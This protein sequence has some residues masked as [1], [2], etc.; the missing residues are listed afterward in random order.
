[1]YMAVLY[2]DIV[3]VSM[4]F[5]VMNMTQNKFNGTIKNITFNIHLTFK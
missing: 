2:L 1:M 4:Q 3:K 5:G